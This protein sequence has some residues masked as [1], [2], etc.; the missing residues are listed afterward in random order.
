[1]R[2]IRILLLFAA[3]VALAT[4]LGG[5]FAS[6]ASAI[7]WTDE[8]CPPDPVGGVLKICHPNAETG[9]PY[10]LQI[11]AREGCTPD[12]V[13]YATPNSNLPPGLS[14]ARSGTGV[15]ISGTPTRS[16][17][18]T[19]WLS[20]TDIPS[21]QG[22][23]FWCSDDHGA[24]RQF[25]INIVQGLQI[26]QRQSTLAAAQTNTPYSLQLTAI[27]GSSLS[28]SVSSGSLPAG[29][30]LNPSTGL[31]SGTP[32]QTGDFTFQVKVAEGSRSDV[33][34]YRLS[35]AEKLQI[36]GAAA[37]AAEVGV[38]FSFKPNA[39]GGRPP[40]KWSATRLPAGLELDEATGAIAG[41]ATAAGSAAV[42]LTATDTLGLTTTLNVNLTVAAKLALV[43]KPL[44][45]AKV[46][47]A[48]AARLTVSGGVRPLKWKATGA[49]TGLKLNAK[50]GALSGTP[51]KAGT[52]RITVR[53]TDK[54]GVQATSALVLKVR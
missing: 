15:L 20:V 19:F 46:G 30:T 10:A 24:E 4:V 31:L 41:T 2:K 32:T 18:Y 52:Y 16:G 26:A 29:V 33:Q 36:T 49:P 7:A 12:S 45:A 25:V 23:I 6:K 39:T 1:M 42:K 28:W 34:T 9:K 53:V 54:L 3:T 43:N 35:V 11:N 8:P 38:L 44:P 40:F 21:W 22:G 51:R 14:M 47:G 27:G 13:S 48:Y 17:S 5:V 37:P 50:T